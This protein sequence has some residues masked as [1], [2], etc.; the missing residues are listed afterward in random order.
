MSEI[1]FKVNDNGKIIN[2]SYNGDMT[3]EQ[4]MRDFSKK[5]TKYESIDYNIYLFKVNGMILNGKDKNNQYK[6]L[7]KKIKEV[8]SNE[9]TVRF[10]RKKLI[11]YSKI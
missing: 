7:G 9:Q 6:Y 8:I 3:C 2:V 1:G 4:F 5:H 10:I 11:S